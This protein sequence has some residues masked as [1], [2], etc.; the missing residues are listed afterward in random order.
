MAV[1]R[2]KMLSSSASFL[3]TF[4]AGEGFWVETLTI[5]ATNWNLSPI[6]KKTPPIGGGFLLFNGKG[7][8]CFTVSVL[9]LY[10]PSTAPFIVMKVVISFSFRRLSVRGSAGLLAEAKIT[11]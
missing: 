4:P 1:V 7:C 9:F 2:T 10:V 11:A 8:Y 5:S 3:G 6:R